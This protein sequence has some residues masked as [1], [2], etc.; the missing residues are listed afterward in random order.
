MSE[1]CRVCSGAQGPPSQSSRRQKPL[2]EQLSSNCS[3]H[4][5]HGLQLLPLSSWGTQGWA[6]HCEPRVCPTA[7]RGQAAPPLSAGGGGVGGVAPVPQ[8]FLEPL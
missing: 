5:Q 8:G 7:G 6:S 1:L 2:E 4:G 3:Q